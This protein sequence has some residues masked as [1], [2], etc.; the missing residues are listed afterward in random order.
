MCQVFT[1]LFSIKTLIFLGLQRE[2][3]YGKVSFFAIFPFLCGAWSLVAFFRT[4]EDAQAAVVC[5][6]VVLG[7]EEVAHAPCL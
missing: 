1:Q 5:P 4:V 7:R 6:L 3:M 2:V